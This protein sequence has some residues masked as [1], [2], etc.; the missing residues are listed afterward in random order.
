MD[1]YWKLGKSQRAEQLRRAIH[2]HRSAQRARSYRG[3][4]H[5]KDLIK[6]KYAKHKVK[7]DK[8]KRFPMTVAKL[9]LGMLAFDITFDAARKNETIQNIGKDIGEAAA[10]TEI[11]QDLAPYLIKF[12]EFIR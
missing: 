6:I 1:R 5:D 2:E 9:G 7:M 12:D 3:T 11:G 8:I 4:V 10:E